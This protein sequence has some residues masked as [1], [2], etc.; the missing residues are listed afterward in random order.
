MPQLLSLTVGT[1]N[2]TY[3]RTAIRCHN[4]LK[5]S[6]DFTNT[7]VSPVVSTQSFFRAYGR[8]RKRLY[9]LTP[10]G[11]LWPSVSDLFVL[12]HFDG[13]LPLRFQ[14]DPACDTRIHLLLRTL[15]YIRRLCRSTSWSVDYPI[16]FLA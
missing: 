7:R 13:L 8:H 15:A 10:F 9:P 6:R 4:M 16:L 1:V 12:P 14:R 2:H 5:A 3:N 11:S